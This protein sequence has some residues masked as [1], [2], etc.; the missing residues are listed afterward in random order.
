V[1]E[2]TNIGD[3]T[4]TH[5]DFTTFRICLDRPA[6]RLGEARALKIC[7]TILCSSVIS[8][9]GK[10]KQWQIAL[11]LLKSM[12]DFGLSVDPWGLAK[13]KA[14]DFLEGFLSPKKIPS[15]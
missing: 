8:A 2:A 1:I 7:S 15:P 10:G 14:M 3:S 6:L 4:I 12:E 9:C 11:D 5:G 13:K